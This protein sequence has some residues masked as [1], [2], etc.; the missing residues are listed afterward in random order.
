[1]QHLENMNKI[2]LP[3]ASIVGYAYAMEFFI[4]WYSG[5]LYERFAFIN[6]A[7]GPVRLGLLDDD[8]LQRD[9]AAALLVQ[10][11]AHAASRCCSSSRSSSTSA[12]GSSASSSSSPRCT[13]T[14]CPSAGTTSG[15]RLGHLD[16]DRQLRPVLH[17]VP[18]VLRFLPMVAIAEVKGVLPQAHAIPH[19]AP[20]TVPYRQ[21]DGAPA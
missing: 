1:M 14:S 20:P 9:L 21:D 3:P 13:A 19:E 5:N 17:A 8:H 4:A 10:E 2:I 16:A 15:R 18:A 7:I 11:A 12:C 6:R